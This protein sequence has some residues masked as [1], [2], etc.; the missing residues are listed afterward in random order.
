MFHPLN[1]GILTLGLS[2][3]LITVSVC[4][5]VLE[6]VGFKNIRKEGKQW[7]IMGGGERSIWLL[8]FISRLNLLSNNFYVQLWDALLE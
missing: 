7:F 8:C 4:I 5:E 1:S 6:K 3:K 2:Q